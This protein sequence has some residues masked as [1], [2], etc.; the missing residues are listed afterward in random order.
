[1][2]EAEEHAAHHETEAG[3]R[4]H[5]WWIE[6]TVSTL[7]LELAPLLENSAVEEFAETPAFCGRL[8]HVVDRLQPQRQLCVNR[9]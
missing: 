6:E 4:D 2:H 3:K 5:R 1:M 8:H 9:A 7:H